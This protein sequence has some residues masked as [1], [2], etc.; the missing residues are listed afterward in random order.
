[1]KEGWRKGMSV[2]AA[3]GADL[4]PHVERMKIALHLG[5]A[6]TDG[7]ALIWSLLKDAEAFESRGTAIPRPRRFRPQMRQIQARLKGATLEPMLQDQLL[8]FIAGEASP[9]RVILSDDSF[10]SMPSKVFEGGTFYSGAGNAAQSLRAMFSNHDCAFYLGMRNPATF[11]A[12]L[13]RTEA[14][15]TYETLLNGADPNAIRWS[16][17]VGAIR[18]ACSDV[19][20]TVWCN[21]DT[22]LV[23][24][25]LLHDISGTDEE[26][27]LS[28]AT[29]I[30]SKL[31][32]PE[33]QL[34]LASSFEDGLPATSDE[35]VDTI[36][37]VLAEHV[38]TSDIE[39]IVDLPAWTNTQ[40]DDITE[41]YEADVDLIAAMEGV[42]VLRP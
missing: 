36:A 17:V 6:C 33:G 21:E 19:P 16:E 8:S 18:A 41:A 7:D 20:L 23:W 29:D 40:V 4:T 1:M 15:L 30:A 11:I 22:P 24:P 5:A 28:G 2:E 10:L 14:P 3:S 9:E 32:G 38:E 34:A 13:V 39:E 27:H 42:Q 26:V 12:E 25:M 35:L 37:D 31:L